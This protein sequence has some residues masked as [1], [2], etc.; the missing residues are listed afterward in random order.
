MEEA[1]GS[2]WKS[3]T[4]E[5]KKLKKEDDN[6]S[7]SSRSV[8]IFDSYGYFNVRTINAIY[9]PGTQLRAR[10]KQQNDSE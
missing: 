3:I 10:E 8:F 6:P 5:E 2:C 9:R 7:R 4:E 1:T